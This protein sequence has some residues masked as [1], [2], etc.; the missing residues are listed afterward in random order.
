[1]F[2]QPSGH[3][4]LN[5]SLVEAVIREA[6]EE[7]AWTFVPEAVSGI[8]QWQHPERNVSFMRVTFAGHVTQ[9]HPERRLDRGIRRTLWLTREEVVQRSSHLRSPMVLQSIDDYLAG[10]RYPLELLTRMCETTTLIDSKSA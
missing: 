3:L 10:K 4:E 7:T 1:V 8:Y 5:E 2:N 6:L 9:H